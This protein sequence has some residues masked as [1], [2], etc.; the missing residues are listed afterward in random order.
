MSALHFAEYD[1]KNGSTV[2][3]TESATTQFMRRLH[4]TSMG[5]CVH[6]RDSLPMNCW[7]TGYHAGYYGKVMDYTAGHIALAFKCAVRFGMRSQ[8]QT[9]YLK[10]VQAGKSNRTID[11][12]LCP[13]CNSTLHDDGCHSCDYR[14]NWVIEEG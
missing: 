13:E 12:T 11:E 14:Q 8:C 1:A 7:D 5:E 9:E 4:F 10:G 3:S 6:L 2:S